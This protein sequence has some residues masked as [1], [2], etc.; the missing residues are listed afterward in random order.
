MLIHKDL[1]TYQ[2]SILRQE[3][4]TS[5]LLMSI[6]T[7]TRMYYVKKFKKRRLSIKLTVTSVMR[8]HACMQIQV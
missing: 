5:D 7:S 8:L 6:T 4:Q 3:A 1:I 2:Q